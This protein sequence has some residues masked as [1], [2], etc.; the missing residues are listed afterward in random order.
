MGL[1]SSL[2][3]SENRYLIRRFFKGGRT[4]ERTPEWVEPLAAEKKKIAPR[5]S[6]APYIPFSALSI[7]DKPTPIELAKEKE[8]P[9]TR[10]TAKATSNKA[11]Q[12][13]IVLVDQQ[14]VFT[15]GRRAFK[16]FSVLFHNP[17]Q[18][19][20]PGELP[21]VD[22]LHAMVAV[23]FTPLK[24]YGSIWQFTPSNLDVERSIQFHEPHGPSGSKISY[25]IARRHG[26][27]LNRA[28]GWTG[29]IFVLE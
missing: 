29:E 22:F 21:W 12:Q 19:D 15:L 20:Q 4:L 13:D 1:L 9:K 18:A 2:A 5:S 17:G 23:G 3:D 14:P 28:Y 11:P 7:S 8:K 24:L 6:D 27:R 16:T 26:R 10:G 25:R